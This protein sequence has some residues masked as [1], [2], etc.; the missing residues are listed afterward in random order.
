MVDDRKHT[1]SVRAFFTEREY[2]D[3]SRIADRED[4][5]VGEMVRVFVRRSMY[6]TIGAEAQEGQQSNVHLGGRE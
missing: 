4:R 6:G 5:K 3:L 2:L 1:E